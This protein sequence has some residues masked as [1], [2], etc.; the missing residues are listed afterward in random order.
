M[1][2]ETTL[3]IIGNLTSPPELRFT[4][5]GAAVTNFTVASTART[6]DRNTNNWRDGETLFLRCS[7]WRDAAEHLAE[8]LSQG[9]RLIVTGRLKQRSFD[10]RDGDKRTV[11]ELDVD[12]IGASLRYATVTVTKAVRSTAPAAD[13]AGDEPPF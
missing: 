1:A 3:T 12:E 7:V 6:Y 8:S 10:A 9:D 13:H 2:G 4:Q 11:L 5:A